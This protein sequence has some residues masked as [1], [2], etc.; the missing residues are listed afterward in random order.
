[1]NYSLGKWSKCWRNCLLNGF[2]PDPH[3]LKLLKPC[4]GDSSKEAFSKISDLQVGWWKVLSYEI[5][6][7]TVTATEIW[8]HL[9]L[10]ETGN[11]GL[12]RHVTEFGDV[13]IK[14]WGP[15]WSFSIIL[16]DLFSCC[17]QR[18]SA[19]CRAQWKELVTCVRSWR[20]AACRLQLFIQRLSCGY[21]VLFLCSLQYD[22]P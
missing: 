11:G 17:T 14:K 21:T 3:L 13:S 6:W 18:E 16:W 22:N 20:W 4:A 9:L 8:W 19:S 2:C 7:N 12:I 15:N 1:M 10:V 5:W